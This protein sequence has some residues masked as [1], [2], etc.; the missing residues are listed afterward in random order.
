MLIAIW[1]MFNTGEL[2][3]DPGGDFYTKR[4]PERAKNRTIE[5]LLHL[6]YV[7]SLEP[8]PAAG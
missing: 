1:N 5:Q 4:N 3:A 8:L 7:V 6:G 2:Y